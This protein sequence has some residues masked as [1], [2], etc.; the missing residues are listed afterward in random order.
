M[1]TNYTAQSLT[2]ALGEGWKIIPLDDI[3]HARK[4][5]NG[6]ISLW[7]SSD[8]RKPERLAVS[9]HAPDLHNFCNRNEEIPTMTVDRTRPPASIAADIRRKLIA[10]GLPLLERLTARKAKHEAQVDTARQHARDLEA[11]SRGTIRAT[12]PEGKDRYSYS[13]DATLYANSNGLYLNGYTTPTSTYFERLSVSPA[14]ARDIAA[15][16][17]QHYSLQ[18]TEA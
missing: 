15:I 13:R 3:E 10:P 5:S 14:C 11:I 1:I 17:A 7:L 16:I 18:T 6:K 12:L 8:W 4:I 2:D 9:I